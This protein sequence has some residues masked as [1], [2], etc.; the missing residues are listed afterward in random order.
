MR[1]WPL[2]CAAL[3]SAAPGC[4]SPVPRVDPASPLFEGR[5]PAE[6]ELLA[7]GRSAYLRKCSGCHPLHRPSRGDARY[8][9]RWVVEMAA[10]SRLSGSE[11]ERIRSYLEAACAA[12][13][14]ASASETA[15]VPEPAPGSER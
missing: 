6:L 12:R 9:D 1:L 3:L 5:P 4:E 7:E 10:R 8:W 15:T 2:L 14:P 13:P 11:E